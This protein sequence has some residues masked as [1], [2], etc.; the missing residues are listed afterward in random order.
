MALWMPESFFFPACLQSSQVRER[1][2]SRSPQRAA[3]YVPTT[4]LAPSSTAR[5][6]SASRARK[7]SPRA[8]TITT[9]CA[10]SSRRRWPPAM[11]PRA[12]GLRVA[13]ELERRQASR[14]RRVRVGGPR[15]G[16]GGWSRGGHSKPPPSQ[17]AGNARLPSTPRPSQLQCLCQQPE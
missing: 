3:T 15:P 6:C 16:Q 5:L 13:A 2:P 10:F 14:R 12:A 17:S 9:C 8:H 4:R 11:S 1:G 7:R